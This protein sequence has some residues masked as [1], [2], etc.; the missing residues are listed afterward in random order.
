[1]EAQLSTDPV[2]GPLLAYCRCIL[3]HTDVH[4]YDRCCFG[5]PGGTCSV[6]RLGK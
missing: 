5:G 2:L 3:K 1:M 6:G 4:V